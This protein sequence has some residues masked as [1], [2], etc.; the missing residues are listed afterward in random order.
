MDNNPYS[1]DWMAGWS[2]LQRKIWDDWSEVT[3]TSWAK[4]FPADNPMEFF[5]EGMSRWQGMFP[6]SQPTPESMAMRH[7]MSSMESFLRMGREVF[8]AFQ[9]AQ[10]GAKPG[11]EW[12]AQ[13]DRV[14]QGAKEMFAKAS[15]PSWPGVPGN[16]DDL[17]VLWNRPMKAWGDFLS[18]NPAFANDTMRALLSGKSVEEQM[19]RFLSAPGLGFFRERQEKMQEGMRLG[20]EYR[21]A[22]EEFQVFMSKSNGTALD[23]LHKKLLEMA[24]EGKALETMRDLYIL[25]VDC[26]EEANARAVTSKEFNELNTH[27]MNGLMRVR[28]HMN[29]TVDNALSLMNMPTRRELDSA[30][31]QI[32][33]LKQRLRALEDE[34]QALR[35]RDASADINTLRDDME[36]LGVRRLREEVAE[37]RKQFQE[38]LHAAPVE[39]A[40]EAASPDKPA[41]KRPVRVAGKPGPAQKGE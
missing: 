23:L 3:Q 11:A 24:A 39:S 10:E 33:T 27:L 41:I 4:S 40:P 13:L 8:K 22:L 28:R 18:N 20:M 17:S 29:E 25:W 30:Y 7:A 6:S 32:A 36:K 34:V 15:M 12:T 19:A 9:S 38:S 37:L 21:K 5:R 2:D 31:Q 14:I 26:S 35:N 16:T 1:T